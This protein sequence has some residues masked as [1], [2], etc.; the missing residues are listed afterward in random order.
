MWNLKKNIL[1]CVRVVKFLVFL[2]NILF[3]FV[4]HSPSLPLSVSERS[5]LSYF[6]FSFSNMIPSKTSKVRNFDKFCV[7]ISHFLGEGEKVNCYS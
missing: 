5:H 3:N 1:Y 4:C 7:H 6:N 2:F